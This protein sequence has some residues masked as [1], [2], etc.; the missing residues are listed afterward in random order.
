MDDEKSCTGHVGI[1]VDR[2]PRLGV[3]TRLPEGTIALPERSSPFIAFNVWVKVGSQNDPKGK[4]GLA[5]LTAFALSEGGT[6]RDSYDAVLEK[7]YPMAA[8]YDY[9]VDKEMTTFTGLI[10]KDNL[11][12]YYELFRNHLIS[13]AF[14][15]E[16]FERVKTQTMNYLERTRRYGRDEE[17]TK[18]LLFSMAFRGTPYEHPE[19][20]YVQ[21]VASITLAD[22]KD[23][24]SRYYVRNNIIVAVGGS[25]PEGFVTRI[26]G[27]FDT[28]PEGE[29]RLVPK[30]K[31]RTADGIEVL[32][33]DKPTDASPVSMGFPISLLRGDPDF[34][35][36]LAMNTWFGLHRS[37]FSH[38]YQVIREARGM[39][40]GNYSY[41][42]AFPLGYTTQLPLVNVSRRSQLFEIWI[43]PI[44]MTA[45]GTLHDR[46]LFAT[47]AAL[48]ELNKLAQNGMSEET[49]SATRRFLRNYTITYGSTLGR[50][51][52]YAVDDVAY[53]IEGGGFLSS[54]RPGLAALQLDTVNES[55]KRHLQDENLYIVTITRDAEE[56]KRKLLSGVPTT[57]TYSG[58]K[59][60]EL[61]REDEEI[62]GFPIPVREDKITII[63]IN[64]VFEVRPSPSESPASNVR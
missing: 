6:T 23:F 58:E 27:E 60:P 50:R 20:G 57:I 11:E 13:P 35:G 46:T 63:D 18:E 24:Y 30:P 40:Y 9:D 52:A 49:L 43:R 55:I 62:A 25:Y 1:D 45:P 19:E 33:V 12:A 41:I 42:E 28:L 64:E 34:I 54:I 39:N 17:L 7:L 21:T 4:E 15:D 38:L 8:E 26:R 14:T 31:P 48:T 29:V 16:D 2:S 5:A 56:L 51:L 59:P 22:V 53:G 37:S 47:R 36:M 10:H 3:G 61:L 44:S 32:I